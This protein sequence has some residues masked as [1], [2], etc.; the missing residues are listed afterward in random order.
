MWGLFRALIRERCM[1]L[2]AFLLLAAGAAF[3]GSKGTDATKNASPPAPLILEGGRRLEYVRS[4]S[5]QSEVKPKKSFLSRVVDFV[6]GPPEIHSMVRPYDLATDG[7][8]RIIVTDPGARLVH[9]FDF[10]NQKYKHLEGSG[11]EDFKSPIGVAVDDQDNLY[12]SDSEL[13]KI[14]VFDAKGKFRR[15]IGNVKGEGYF[16]RPTGLAVDSVAKRLYVTDTIKNAVYTLDLEGNILGHFGQRGAEAGQFNFPTEILAVKDELVVV[17]AMNFRVQIFDRSGGFRA[18][19]GEAGDSTGSMFR[20][21][22]LAI[23]SEGDLYL[24]DGYLDCVQVFNRAGVLL[25]FFGQPGSGAM[26]FQ[27]PAG[28]HIDRNDMVYVVDS[29]NRRVQ[30]FHYVAAPARMSTGGGQ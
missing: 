24:A 14:F 8:G 2:P 9:V 13:G 25:Y 20:S 16:K 30:Q 15:Y 29:A 5:S 4:F 19:F 21:K 6:A 28:V 23:D 11:K 27:S 26:Q 7:Q 22:G 12:V 10:K 18:K 1:V 3:A 17:D